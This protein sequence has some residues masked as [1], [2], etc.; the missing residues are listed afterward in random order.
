MDRPLWSGSLAFGI[1]T[2]PVRL[3]AA[4]RD[5]DLHF[6]Q[7][8]RT[9]R[10]RIRYRKVAEGG[11]DEVPAA[12]IVKGFEVKPGHYVVFDDDEL[13]KLAARKSRVIDISSFVDLAEIDP[14]Y[15]D[16]PY[17]L[18]PDE[19]GEK[20]YRLLTQTLER[21]GR[22]GVAQMVMHGKE[23]IVAL[24]SI[25][26]RLYLH[27]LRFADE[28]VRPAPL[29]VG[30]KLSERELSMAERLIESMH[31]KFDPKTFVDDYRK[32]LQTAIARKAQG[33]TLAIQ[34]QPDEPV[35]GKAGNLLEALEKSLAGGAHGRRAAGAPPAK[36][37]RTTRRN[38]AAPVRKQTSA[39]T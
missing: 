10:K 18:V 23:H 24:R 38:T 33:K 13:T 37:V 27:T 30:S 39:R 7:I 22:T 20:P 31:E 8:S 11:T 17:L 12:D 34:E 9:D 36:S 29:A 19:Q 28:V 16:R 6:H 15:F 14:L 26:G 32:R 1:V 25:A 3:L 5:H 21:T 2:I 4:P 35:S